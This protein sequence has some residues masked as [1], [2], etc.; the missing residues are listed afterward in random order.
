MIQIKDIQTLQYLMEVRY[1]PLLIQILAMLEN[2]G[3][4]FIILQAYH[5]DKNPKLPVKELLLDPSYYPNNMLYQ[6]IP[7]INN[8]WQYNKSNSDRVAEIIE[9]KHNRGTFLLKLKVCEDTKRR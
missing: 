7:Q 9:N 5:P 8:I 4:G 6:L 1:E 3:N 2:N